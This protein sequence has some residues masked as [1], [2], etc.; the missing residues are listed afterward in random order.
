M[1]DGSDTAV[2]VNRGWIPSA[3]A[4]RSEWGKYN[5]PGE[6]TVTGV[7]RCSQT[8]I[9]FNMK[10]DATPAPG[11][12]KRKAWSYVNIEEIG[13]Q[14]DVP[15]LNVYV[16]QYPA[17]GQ[18]ELPMASELDIEITEGP[19][20][21]YA[22]QWFTFSTVLFFGYPFYVRKQMAKVEQGY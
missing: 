19:H 4:D 18:P 7:I 20:L 22:I 13:K 8:D 12:E 2:L 3:D 16:H 15:L 10:A 11:E 6:A 21:N 9:V 14:V 5:Q 1:I 17:A